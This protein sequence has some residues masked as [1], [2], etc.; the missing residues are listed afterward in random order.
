MPIVALR[1]PASQ[2]PLEFVLTDADAMVAGTHLADYEQLIVTARI[3][4]SG[5]ATDV[6]DGLESWSGVISPLEQQNIEL[7]ISGKFRCQYA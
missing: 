7:L 2:L 6:I 3:S 1:R 5:L 4:R